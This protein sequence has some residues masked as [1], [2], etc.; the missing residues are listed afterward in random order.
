VRGLS[1]EKRGDF[2]KILQ[3]QIQKIRRTKY[4]VLRA[5]CIVLGATTKD[6]TGIRARGP[7]RSNYS[8]SDSLIALLGRKSRI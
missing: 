1:N 6:G 3:Q 8:H 7:N 2:A 4:K 5:E